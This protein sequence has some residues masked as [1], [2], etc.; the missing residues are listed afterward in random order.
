[1]TSATTKRAA[2][3]ARVSTDD[4]TIANQLLVLRE[5][6]ERSGW[7]VVATYADE[8]V[9]GATDRSCR[10]GLDQLMRAVVRREVDVVMAW[11]V[12]RL[13]RSLHHV[14]AL[15]EELRVKGVDLYLHQQGFDTTTPHGRAML[16]MCGVFAELERALIGERTRAGLRRARAEGKRLG[17]PRVPAASIATARKAL[18]GGA[19]VRQAALS[20]GVG[21]GTVQRLRV[22]LGGLG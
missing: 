22:E 20:A 18:M 10:R 17:R 19:S 4:Q 14:L 9:S 1:M 7:E 13:G 16:Q 12:D 8:G 6:A 2:I 5:V 15:F 3:Y 21:K 11:S